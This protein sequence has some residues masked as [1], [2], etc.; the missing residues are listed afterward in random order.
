MNCCNRPTTTTQKEL[1]SGLSL[2]RA[3]AAAA[4][5]IMMALV[6]MM[7]NDVKKKKKKK[8][9]DAR[10]HHPAGPVNAKRLVCSL[11]M[12]MMAIMA[13]WWKIR[14]DA[15]QW[16]PLSA[17]AAS[18]DVLSACARA[19]ALDDRRSRARPSINTSSTSGV[20]AMGVMNIHRR[21]TY[22]YYYSHPSGAHFLFNSSSTRR[23]KKESRFHI[24]I[25]IEMVVIIIIKG[26]F[27]WYQRGHGVPSLSGREYSL[28]H[29]TSFRWS[30]VWSEIRSCGQTRWPK[31]VNNQ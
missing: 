29:C 15:A 14:R 10:R 9:L 1:K 18:A 3:A 12:M 27:K 6:M 25:S 23:R 16:I 20:I 2:Y 19:R 17:A 5:I 22:R 30:A 28:R 26:I 24:G 7:M 11:L 4:E 21:C 8:K 13:R 31:G